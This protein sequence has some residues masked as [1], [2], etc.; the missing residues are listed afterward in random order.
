MNYIQVFL[1]RSQLKHI[2]L[3][4]AYLVAFAVAELTIINMSPLRGMVLYG[5]L[6]LFLFINAAMLWRQQ[7]QKILYAIIF[8]PL[9]RL[10]SLGLPLA[11][12]SLPFW[13]LI[14]GIPL[15]VAAFFTARILGFSRQKLGLTFRN[16]PF[17]LVIGLTGVLFGFLEYLI[18]TPEPLVESFTFKDIWLAALILLWFTGFLEETIFRGLIQRAS[19]ESL[20]WIGIPYVAALFAIL[21]VGYNSLLDVLFVFFVG[22]FFGVITLRTGSILGA[23]LSHGLTN[24]TLFLIF[25]FLLSAP[26]ATIYSPTPDPQSAPEIDVTSIPPNEINESIQPTWL[27]TS[28]PLIAID[29]GASTNDDLLPPTTTLST[30]TVPP[31]TPSPTL[32]QQIVDDGSPGFIRIGGIQ[33]TMENAFGGDFVWSYTVFG[34]ASVQVE[35]IPDIAACGVYSL[36]V[37][38]PPDFPTFQAARYYIVHGLGTSEVV[39]DQQAH[40]GQW[41]SLGSYEFIPGGKSILRLTN[42]TFDEFSAEKIAVFDA[43]RWTFIVPCGED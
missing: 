8:A 30:K 10:L 23:S 42:S 3:V 37:F 6:L 18:L 4:S 43:A 7:V 35:W 33:W 13:F 39:L 19:L 1:A 21:H 24:I 15:F 40:Q 17:Q 31:V 41:A 2:W 12:F 38:I 32:V 16:L 22:L 34:D 26:L 27:S 36:D 28:L 14:T 25:P 29:E 20:G 5:I 11:N 9:I